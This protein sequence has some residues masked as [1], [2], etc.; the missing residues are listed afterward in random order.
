MKK[1]AAKIPP[2]VSFLLPEFRRAKPVNPTKQQEMRLM[3]SKIVRVIK[4]HL[5]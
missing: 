5:I 3:N 1:Y 2:T 4:P